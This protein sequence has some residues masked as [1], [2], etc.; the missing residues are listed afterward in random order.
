MRT[1]FL[2]I[3]FNLIAIPLYSQSATLKKEQQKPFDP[4]DSQELLTRYPA[5]KTWQ[6]LSVMRVNGRGSSTNWGLVGES[7]FIQANRYQTRITILD[8]QIFGKT[9]TIKLRC[10]VIDASSSK[11]I[12]KESLRLADFDSSDP[13]FAYALKK[14]LATVEFISPGFKTVMA[15][16]RKWEE[17]DPNYQRSLTEIARR[18]GL[19]PGQLNDVKDLQWM[20]TPRV[21]SGCSFEVHWV[22][23]IGVTKA[24]QVKSPNSEAQSL[25]SE[26]INRWLVGANPLAELYVFP[27]LKKAVG[28]S[29]TLD[30]SRA[31]SIFAGQGDATS[32]GEVKL[33]YESDGD[34][35]GNKVRQVYIQ[36]GRIEV[37]VASEG[38][39]TQYRINAMEGTMK[40]DHRDAMLMMSGGTGDL[41]YSR[42]STDHFLFKAELR[43]DIS[44]QW[45]YEAK[46][47]GR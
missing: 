29:W 28:D 41:S 4:F 46:R 45:R 39:E 19:E 34:Y 47:V 6:S 13:V 23:G 8:N 40:I 25:S 33:R 18:F 1:I 27:S 10:D 3:L 12:T 11:I 5:G 37:V 22:N 14:G 15:V 35:D 9:S 17:I 2:A 42:L 43:R 31:T 26:D 30:A 36:N 20:E 44:C 32:E 24:T 38:Q 21:Y 16:L 7:Q